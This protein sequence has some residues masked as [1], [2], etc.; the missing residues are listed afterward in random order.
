MMGRADMLSVFLGSSYRGDLMAEESAKDAL[1]GVVAFH[2]IFPFQRISLLDVTLR[3]KSPATFHPEAV[4]MKD[5]FP[6]IVRIEVAD[7][8]TFRTPQHSDG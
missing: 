3:Q 6:D 1:I 5:S 4:E 8:V 2:R 7:E